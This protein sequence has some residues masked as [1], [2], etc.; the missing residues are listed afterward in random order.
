MP[1]SDP[2]ARRKY[3]REW[4]ARRK[5][6]WYADK[7]CAVCGST[8]DLELD[9]VD[10]AQKVSHSIW[11]WSW[12]RIA[13]ETA[14]CQVLCVHHHD[15]KTLKNREYVRGEDVVISRLT[16]SQVSTAK[17]MRRDGYLYREIGEFLDATKQ[18]AW[19]VVN[20]GWQH[21]Q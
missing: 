19:W 8:D 15:A 16:E 20:K 6:S 1:I 14:K 5:A 10:P 12:E 2:D 18:V 4:V 11:S 13:E 3:Q 7:S 21:V 9:H 17:Q